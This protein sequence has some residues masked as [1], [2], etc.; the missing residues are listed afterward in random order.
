MSSPASSILRAMAASLA[1]FAIFSMS[2]AITAQ[3]AEGDETNPKFR[4]AIQ[5][6]LSLQGSVEQMGLSV[7][8][9]AAN[10]TLMAIAQ[11]GTQVTEPMQNIVLEQAI[12]TYADKFGDIE[13]LTDLWAP[14]YA[15]HY[16][17]KE[18]RTLIDFYRSPVGKKTLELSG[19]I[20]EASMMAIR[21]AQ[22]AMTP[23][24]QMGVN[25]KLE[26]AGIAVTGSQAT[27]LP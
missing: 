21:E 5:T 25:A 2:A 19:P 4:E 23:G 17:E 18:I 6:Y 16:T 1:L 3:A 8:Y 7:A 27:D 13:Y 20:N 12:A 15:K 24:F 14:V 11:T 9:N 10:E 22:I 26:A